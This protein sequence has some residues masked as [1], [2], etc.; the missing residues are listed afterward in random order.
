VT[1]SALFFE[2]IRVIEE[3]LEATGGIYPKAILFENVVGLLSSSNGEDF[4][5]VLH[6]LQHLG[7]GFIL[8][9]NILDASRMGVPQRRRRVYIAGIN[10]KHIEER[11]HAGTGDAKGTEQLSLFEDS[12]SEHDNHKRLQAL[13]D[14][15]ERHTGNRGR[16]EIPID[17]G[18][19]FRNFEKGR[20]ARE[21]SSGI[22]EADLGE[23]DRLVGE[24]TAYGVVTKGNGDSFLRE[25]THTALTTGGGQ[26]GQGYPCVLIKSVKDRVV[27]YIVRKLTLKECL[28]LQGMPRYWCDGLANRTPTD[29]DIVYWSK[30]FEEYSLVTNSK[31]KTG[32]QIRKWLANPYSETAGYK[33]TGNGCASVQAYFCLK[34]I[35]EILTTV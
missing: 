33:L 2:A 12:D 9:P 30:V 29:D 32:A 20:S 28:R 25:E 16:P 23:A 7:S 15:L 31:P 6:E 17:C 24:A 26:A 19:L 21:E 35:K 4:I 27:D 1:A 18:S 3:M 5:R 14:L 13:A 11:F 34:K 10:S 22:I 8:D